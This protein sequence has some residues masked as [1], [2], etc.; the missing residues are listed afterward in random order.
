MLPRIGF[1][2]LIPAVGPPIFSRSVPPAAY[3]CLP[4]FLRWSR[5]PCGPATVA[6]VTG[7]LWRAVAP[8]RYF[9]RFTIVEIPSRGDKVGFRLLA[10]LLRTFPLLSANGLPSS[11]RLRISDWRVI[12]A[13][14]ISVGTSN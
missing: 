7:M 9:G 14:V 6:G 4:P 8:A 12:L 5:S 2:S 3:T 1:G 11:W 10:K 13:G